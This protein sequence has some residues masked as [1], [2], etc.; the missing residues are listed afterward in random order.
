MLNLL[1]RIV[2][3][4]LDNPLV[5]GL[6]QK[7][8]GGTTRIYRAFIGERIRV[9]NDT[10]LLDV[11]CGIGNFRDDFKCGYTGV[12]INPG[13]V[14]SARRQCPGTE[15][16]VMSGTGLSF[17]DE[18]FDQ[19]VTIATL[20]HIDDAG[21]VD[22]IQE[23]RRVCRNSGKVHIIEAIYPLKPYK[24]LNYLV[25]AL[26]RGRHQRTFEQLRTLLASQLPIEVAETKSGFPHDVCYI[27]IPALTAPVAV[28]PPNA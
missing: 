19:V 22:T 11:G 18:E 17:A 13:F 26:D 4:I 7:Y 3:R 12:D 25:F 28:E 14:E 5:F 10:R 2:W 8:L 6:T 1:K 23:A 15:F 16:H 27:S 9:A 20:H 24:I 21:V